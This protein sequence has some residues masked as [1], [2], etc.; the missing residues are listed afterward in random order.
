MA[1]HKDISKPFKLVDKKT[2]EIRRFEAVGFLNED[3]A[4]ISGNEMMARVAGKNGGAID[5]GDMEFV[6]R[7]RDL[8][9]PELQA[10]D[11]VTNQR[12]CPDW[13]HNLVCF[14]YYGYNREWQKFYESIDTRWSQRAL[15]L[16]R[17]P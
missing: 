3:E 13:P 17:C 12:D 5:D 16:R 8:L 7:H 2:G 9:P 14:D 6:W 15:V 11:L 10:H 1:I 4:P